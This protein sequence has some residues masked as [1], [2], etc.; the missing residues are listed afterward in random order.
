M[1][2]NVAG[3]DVAREV[4]GPA[5]AGTRESEG[6]RADR[7]D[8]NGAS[9]NGAAAMT[10]DGEGWRG[11]ER[12]QPKGNRRDGVGGSA[13]GAAV[14]GGEKVESREGSSWRATAG[15]ASTGTANTGRAGTR[16]A[17]LRAARRLW[18]TAGKGEGRRGLV[19]GVG[20]A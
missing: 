1:T 14:P 16:S 4:E 2:A 6:E 7:T 11:A 12:R 17:G 10:D 15:R 13:S 3:V 19:F 5:E 9:P 8:G 18:R 20:M